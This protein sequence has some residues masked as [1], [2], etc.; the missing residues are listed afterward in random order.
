LF[1]LDSGVEPGWYVNDLSNLV[2]DYCLT[3]REPLLTYQL[4]DVVA[5]IISMSIIT[6][7]IVAGFSMSHRT[8][9]LGLWKLTIN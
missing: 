1:V 5:S 4:Y 9:L 2:A 3:W 7:F 6:Y 8:K